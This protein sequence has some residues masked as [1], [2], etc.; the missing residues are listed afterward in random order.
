[1][2]RVQIQLLGAVGLALLLGVVG[3]FVSGRHSSS[4]SRSDDGTTSVALT[5]TGR[6]SSLYPDRTGGCVKPDAG[7]HVEPGADTHCGPVFAADG[8]PIKV[9]AVVR[10]TQFSLDAH[11]GS[12]MQG[13]LLTSGS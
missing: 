5:F 6:I 7:Q 8:V 9:G 13:L 1:M 2:T 11:D 10:A 4:G 3:G 12:A